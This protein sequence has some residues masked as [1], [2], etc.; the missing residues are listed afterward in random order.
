MAHDEGIF[1]HVSEAHLLEAH[2]DK[3]GST[4]DS[5]TMDNTSSCRSYRTSSSTVVLLLLFLV[6]GVLSVS[7]LS[8]GLAKDNAG[9]SAQHIPVAGS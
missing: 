3:T 2:M 1:A 7:S 6:V 8:D 5:C 9:K 4:T